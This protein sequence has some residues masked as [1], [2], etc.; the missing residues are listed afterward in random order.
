L[1][2]PGVMN[3]LRRI[4]HQTD[5]P[6][7]RLLVEMVLTKGSCGWFMRRRCE[8]LLA[9]CD[10]VEAAFALRGNWKG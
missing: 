9:H 3:L 6:A 1:R 5:T 7:I 2:Q 8:R 4:L 10:Q